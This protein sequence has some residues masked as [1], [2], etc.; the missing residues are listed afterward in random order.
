M[1]SSN[2]PLYPKLSSIYNKIMQLAIGI[3]LIVV[4]L[5]LWVTSNARSE[6]TIHD[7]FYTLAKQQ[8]EQAISTIKSLQMIDSHDELNKYIAGVAQSDW[9]Y[10]ARIYDETGKIIASSDNS[11]S[12]KDV[13]GITL[14]KSNKSDKYV[15]FIQEIR[16]EKLIGYIRITV[17]KAYFT[18]DLFS[19]N[20]DNHAMTRLMML[21]AVCIGFL[22]T[23][24][25]NR[26]SRQGYRPPIEK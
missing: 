11:L 12:I 8:L 3:V 15:P 22:L 24:G 9:V 1:K 6:K 4:L 17:K 19:T 16:T 14:N 21:I 13:Y 18:D 7:H 23:R 5:N 20:Y 25:L 10:D 2:L 26:F